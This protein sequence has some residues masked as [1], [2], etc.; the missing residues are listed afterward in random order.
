MDKSRVADAL[1]EIGHLLELQGA[2]VFRTNAY[3][4]AARALETFPG[5]FEGAV[6]AGTLTSIPGVGKGLAGA[7]TELATKGQYDELDELRAKTPPGLIELLRVPGLGPKK[8]KALH[9]ELGIVDRATLEV[10]CREGKVAPLKGFGEKTQEKLLAGLALLA[11]SAGLFRADVVRA[12]AA[13]LLRA[14]ESHPAVVRAALC[15]SLRRWKEISKDVDLLAASEHPEQVMNAFLAA[16]GEVTLI[17]RGETKCSVRFANGL[18]ADLRV[19]SPAAFPFALHYFTGSREHNTQL[20]ARAKDRGL[21]LNE[22]GLFPEGSEASLACADEE[23]LFRALGLPWIAPELREGLGEIEAAE[24]GTLPAMVERAQCCNILHMHTTDSDGKPTL[25]QYVEWAAA[26]G[27]RLMG[28]AD[29]SRSA[30]Y[31]GGLSVE[32]VADQHRRIEALN[33]ARGAALGVKL[34]R[35]IESDILADGSLDYDPATLATFDFIVASV[36]SRFGMPREEMTARICRAVENPFT[37]VLGHPT[38]RLLLEREPYAV[39][40]DAVIEAAARSG[41]AIEINASPYRLDLDWR[42]VRRAVER[43]CLLSIGPDAHEL[44]G[45]DDMDFGIGIARK[46][47]APPERII[48]TWAPDRLESWLADRRA[49]AIRAA[50]L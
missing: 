35:G 40:L 10:A 26:R 18:Q 36:H 33:A 23:A 11:Q 1:R 44:E 4:N 39:D 29:H 9:E 13:P 6:T 41:V 37:S 45:L 34:L 42:V 31:A 2:N 24:A 15:G 3:H 21:K 49:R 50:G 47:W 25:E 17:G 8:L 22:Y 32:R 14:I 28:I 16:A 43:G 19:V 7:I 46:G 5:D 12:A 20:R 27:V 38:G 30:A 48:N